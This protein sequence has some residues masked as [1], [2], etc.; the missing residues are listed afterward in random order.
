M[1][2]GGGSLGLAHE[3]CWGHGYLRERGLAPRYTSISQKA[4]REYKEFESMF[5]RICEGKPSETNSSSM[6]TQRQRDAARRNIKKAQAARRGGSN[7]NSSRRSNR[8]SGDD[9]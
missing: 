4:K 8:G 5:V 9:R 7:G 3:A 1:Q 2:L 6:A